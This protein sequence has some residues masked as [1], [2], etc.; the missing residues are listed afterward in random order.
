[1]DSELIDR[2]PLGA[3]VTVADLEGDPHPHLARLRSREPVSWLPALDGWL[4]TARRPAL[5]VMRDAAAF[6]V[7]DPR[8]ST[9]RLLGPS[10]LSLDGRAHARHREPFARPFRPARTRE[11]FTAF[12]RDEAARLTA[13]LAPAG[14]AELRGELAG[15]LAV[16]VVAEA[17][18]LRGADAA[19]VR[20]WYEAF[21]E[22]V[23]AI[24]TGGEPDGR[25]DEAYGRL[26][27]AVEEAAAAPGSA[28]L[29]AEAA[30][31]EEGLT[32]AEVVANA[33]VLMF[34]G[35]DTTEGM[36]A[37]AVL[38]LLGHPAELD[39]VRADRA[40]LPAAIEE[41]LRLE[42]SASVVD[43]YATRDVEL[44]GAPIREGDLVRVSLAGAN[45][46]PAAFP[47]PDR[48][49][50]RR[51]NA[52]E[53]LAFAHGPH[54]CFGAHLA[55]LE[56]L[57]VLEELLDRLPGLRLAPGPVP[58]PRGLVFRKP[59]TLN[60]RWNVHRGPGPVP[61]ECETIAE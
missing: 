58:E 50:V 5:A 9:A 10:M 3:A 16:A 20:S 57:T 22:A 33:A 45:R 2:F 49:D 61:P 40:L 29:L 38:H 56:T 39:L 17:L 32:G 23:S 51:A 26:R 30:H 6:T 15:P 37:N 41:S 59:E 31:Q 11:R 34:G 60:V 46:D 25:A 21:V 53:H 1:M 52:G 24:T 12:V 42:P 55:R 36:I 19:T 47:D 13:A 14:E 28:S 48:Y 4:V 43:R 8:F 54:F 35:I 18:G 7:D 44:E 27:D